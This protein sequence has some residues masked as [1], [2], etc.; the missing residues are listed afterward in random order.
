MKKKFGISLGSAIL[1]AAICVGMVFAFSYTTTDG[2]WGRI[3]AIPGDGYTDDADCDGWGMV[4]NSDY[5]M[6]D[7]IGVIYNRNYGPGG[8]TEQYV[9]NAAVCSGDI[10][11]DGTFAEWT[12]TTSIDWTG[13][14]SHTS[15]CPT[16]APN[17]YISEYMYDDRG[18]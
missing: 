9:R 16:N 14:G 8:E 3:D 5:T 15:T 4:T 13:F 11:G 17:L 1:L 6:G 2:T 18:G 7:V 12:R 10:D